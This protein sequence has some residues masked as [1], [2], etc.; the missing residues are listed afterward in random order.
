M[1]RQTSFGR[2]PFRF[3]LSVKVLCLGCLFTGA[4]YLGSISNSFADDS[5]TASNIDSDLQRLVDYAHNRARQGSPAAASPKQPAG[6]Q[7]QKLSR[8]DQEGR[9]LVHVH[10]D[11]NQ[12]MEAME[13]VLTSLHATVLAKK[14]SYRHGVVAAYLPIEQIETLARTAGVSHLNAE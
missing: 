3:T 11:G 6:I 14:E 2:K 9:V 5:T 12:S 8:F 10:L 1:G 4:L 7:L 13:R